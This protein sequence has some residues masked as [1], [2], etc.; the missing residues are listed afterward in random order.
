LPP[1]AAKT[2]SRNAHDQ[3]RPL[4]DTMRNPWVAQGL[5]LPLAACG[6]GKLLR[7]S[8]ICALAPQVKGKVVGA[9]HTRQGR[10]PCTLQGAV[11]PLTPAKPAVLLLKGAKAPPIAAGC[12]RFGQLST[13]W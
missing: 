6:N 8:V 11:G 1:L 10:C 12:D 9:A 4:I 13:I 3:L 2:L 7:P 5:S